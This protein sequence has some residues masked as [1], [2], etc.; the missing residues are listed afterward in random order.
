MIRDI[1]YPIA[2]DVLLGKRVVVVCRTRDAAERL[3]EDTCE[4]LSHVDERR[5]TILSRTLVIDYDGHPTCHGS[6]TFA[7]DATRK[8]LRGKTFDEAFDEDGHRIDP[9]RLFPEILVDPDED[10]EPEPE[11]RGIGPFTFMRATLSLHDP[12]KPLDEAW[13][14]LEDRLESDDDSFDDVFGALSRATRDVEE[15]HRCMRDMELREYRRR[16]GELPKDF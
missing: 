13:T 1:A 3:F 2:L 15:I 8:M 6:A 9:C 16:Y 12:H 14:M 11:K 4:H 10:E 7:T 5:L